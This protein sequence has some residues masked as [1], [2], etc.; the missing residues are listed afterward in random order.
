MNKDSFAYRLLVNLGCA[1]VF[2][3]GF[4]FAANLIL[5][6]LTRHNRE[7][8]VPDLT[9]MTVQ[10]ASRVASSA[11]LTAHVADSIFMRRVARGS[12]VS[13]IPAPGSKVK[14]GRKISLTINSIVPKKVKMPGLVGCS[15]R[16]AKAELTSRELILGRLVYVSDI[17]TNN[18]LRQTCRGLDIAAG[19]E[20]PSGSVINLYLGLN[21]ADAHAYVP[22]VVGMKYLQAV[23]AIHD[24]SLNVGSLRFDSTVHDYADS[25][26]AVV[27]SQRP[28]PTGL[29][30]V[31]GGDITVSLT[32]DE[33]KLSR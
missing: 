28:A 30:M 14:G 22:N 25:L 1:L 8:T 27:Y 32:L 9:N 23:D 29:P 11:G 19:D 2:V 4:A 17:A 26:N 6:M 3:L 7:V 13:Q 31:M 20:I 24:N 16:Q 10:E 33:S 15:L 18:V 12:V 21:S 5:G